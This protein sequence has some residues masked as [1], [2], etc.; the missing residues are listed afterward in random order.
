VW[1]ANLADLELHVLLATASHE[2]RPTVIAFDLDPGE[3]AGIVEC[4]EVALHV[5]DLFDD[6]GLASFP[7]TSGSKGIQV[8]IPL[9]DPKVTYEHTKPFAKAVAELLTRKHPDL[10]VAKQL[11]ELRRGKVLVDW[12][13][14]DDHKTTV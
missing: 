7:K 14:N 11:K 4:C 9:N 12:S 5:H 3:G 8:Y 2:Q 6:F 1:A 13:Q 10:V